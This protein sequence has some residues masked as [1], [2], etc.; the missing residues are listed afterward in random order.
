MHRMDRPVLERERELAEIAQAARDAASG[1]GCVIHV[2]GEAG[3]GKTR[4]LTTARSLMPAEGRVLIGHCDDL[5][6]ARILGPFRDLIGAVG[7]DLDAALRTDIDY[8][9]FLPALRAELEWNSRPTLLAIEDVHW[10]DDATLDALHYLIRRID[11]LP[12]VLFLTY[13]DDDLPPDHPVR[14]LLG[15][16]AADGA[17]R[18]LP[19]ERLTYEA[20][21]DLSD[22]TNLDPGEI[23]AVTAGNP[24]FVTEVVATGA[25]AKVPKSVAESVMAR[26]LR[27]GPQTREAVEVLATIPTNIDRWLLDRVVAGGLATLVPAEQS[28]LLTVGATRVTFRHELTRRAIL[29]GLPAVRRMMLNARVLTAMIERNDVDLARIMH[30]AAEADDG[31]VIVQYG[32]RAAQSAAAGAAHR[33]AEAYFRSVLRYADQ[34]DQRQ[35]A[36]LLEGHGIECH[37]LGDSARAIRSQEQAIGIHRALGNQV[38][39]GKALRWLSRMLWWSGDRPG[40]EAAALEAV[41]VLEQTGADV[42]LALAYSNFAMLQILAYRY[43]QALP[44]A[45]RAVALA[46]QTDDPGTLSHAL[47]NLGMIRSGLGGEGLDLLREGLDVAL[48]AGETDAACRVYGNMVCHLVDRHRPAEAEPYAVAGLE[49][50]DRTEHLSWQDPLRA[51]RSRILLALGRWDEAV[52]L[53]QTVLDSQPAFRCIGLTVIGRIAARRGDQAA[54]DLLVAALAAG[55]QAGELQRTGPAI[56][57]SVEAAWL[58]GDP[59]AVVPAAAATY[60]ELRELDVATLWPELGY[61]LARAGHPVEPGI[62]FDNPYQLLAAGRWEE[63]AERWQLA[64]CRY[65]HALA[66]AES[67]VPELLVAA[68]EELDALGARPLARILRQRLRNLGGAPVPRG[69]AISTRQNPEGLTSRQLEVL[70]LLTQGLTDAEIAGRLVVSVRTASNHV[71]AVL[72]KLGAANRLEAA[73]RAR[74]WASGP[75]D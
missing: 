39:L 7:H 11:Q 16:A 57:A 30:H 47:N 72:T 17:V 4:L 36:E 37:T 42:P 68:I 45:E 55:G 27:L 34:F 6:T 28:G 49:L 64:G 73:S 33:E 1:R 75:T 22:G 23:F 14:R 54:S 56:A 63:A 70:D 18:R 19:L 60:A 21:R 38:E 13:R 35:L 50:A 74:Q 71:A 9:R 15:V 3:I 40:A 46:R 51:H 44:M 32:P 48:A 26:V 25:I 31:P 67:A 20:V 12:L 24:F 59:A 65:E 61:W 58:R 10:A 41:V 62:P 2:S 66:L 5:T 29:D 8:E 52:E 69:T 43:R 53:A